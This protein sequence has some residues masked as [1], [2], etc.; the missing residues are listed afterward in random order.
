MTFT[1]YL[2]P[3]GDIQ[4]DELRNIR[5]ISTNDK[6]G[7]DIRVWLQTVYGED[8]FNKLYGLDV[9]SIG[10]EDDVRREISRT[11]SQIPQIDSFEILSVTR[12]NRIALLSLFIIL[13]SGAAITFSLQL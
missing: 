9:F 7:Q 10:S 8:Y 11:L 3:L 4:F 12:T 2:D 1:F 6:L 13:K 5:M